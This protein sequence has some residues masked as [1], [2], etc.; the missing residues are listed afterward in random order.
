MLLVAVLVPFAAACGSAS[1][2]APASTAQG[3]DDHQLCVQLFTRNRECTD[4]YIPALVDAR[5]K[6][7]QPPGIAEKVKADRDGVIA[8]A[9]G[10]WAEDSKDDAIARTCQQL[11]ANMTDEQRGSVDQARS[12]LTQTDCGAY[13]TCVMPLFEKRFQ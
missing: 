2:A 10:E 6:Y 12:C 7:D 1:E 4:Q 8:I 11:V 9:K 13:T 5:A 3:G